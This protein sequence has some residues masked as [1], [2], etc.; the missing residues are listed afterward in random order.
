VKKLLTPF[1]VG[2]LVLASG[3]FFFI[4]MT[5]VRKGGLSDDESVTVYAF[6][7]DAGGLGKKSR[8]QIAGIAVGEV[9]TIVLEGTRAKV[10]LRVRKEIGLRT[11]ATVTKRSEGLLGDY[12]LDLTPGTETQPLLRDGDGP[13]AVIEGQGME[14]IFSSLNRITADIEEVTGSL[15]K[16]LG[17]DKGAGSLEHIFQNMVTLSDSLDDT[18][19]NSSGRLETILK[20]V[21]SFSADIRDISSGN[22]ETIRRIVDNTAIITQ[23]VRD[24]LTTVKKIVGS[25]EGDL[26]ESVASLKQTLTRLDNSLANIEQITEK[27]RDGKGAVGTLLTDERIGQK[28]SESVEDISDFA[29]QLTRLQTEVGI[30]S[31]YLLSQGSAKNSLGIR[32]IPKPDKYYLLEIIDDPRGVVDTQIV[33][34]NPPASGEPVTQIQRITRDDL[35]FSA[36]FAK[37]YYFTTLRF[38]IIESTGGA[39]ADV[40]FFNDHVTLKMDAFNFSVEEL[41]YPRL[42]ATLRLQA[43]GHLFA[44]AGMDDILNRQVRDSASNKLIAGR[45]IFFGAGVFFT[46]DD[47]K[48]VLTAAPVPSP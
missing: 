22:D 24:V 33:Q 8:V 29:S 39:G 38:G 30:K 35:K 11:D 26:K 9:D 13:I 19:R 34:S 36:Q 7:R 37:R 14:A 17:G 1:R 20:N 47:L 21:E 32:L 42:R 4:F 44:T 27:V 3:V 45:D 46:D 31:E 5:F 43:F 25:G 40:H 2:L 6:F 16:V 18:V 41:R 12:Q 48:A 23:D 15:S 10:F 28:I